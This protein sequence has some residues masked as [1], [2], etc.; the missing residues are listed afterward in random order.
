MH[1][2]KSLLVFLVIFLQSVHAQDHVLTNELI[3][4]QTFVQ[5]SL[6]SIH[7]LKSQSAY[8]VIK[9]DEVNQQSKIVLYDY[10]TKTELAVLVDSSRSAKI[11]FFT[12]YSFS[13]D[14]QKILLESNVEPIYRRS[15]RAEYWVY[16]RQTKQV[17]YLFGGKVQQA[18]FSPDGSKVAFVYQRNLFFKDLAQNSIEQ[19]TFDG[20]QHII[21]GLTDWV[22]E[23]EFGFVRA[24][25]WNADGT[26]IAFMRFDETEVP[27]FSMDIYGSGLYQYPYRFK[28]PKAGENNATVSLHLYDLAKK[29]TSEIQLLDNKPYYIPRFEF[30]PQTNRLVVQT[31]NRLQN[32]LILWDLDIESKMAKVL[33]EEKSDTYVDVHDNL[34]F[35]DR[36]DFIWTS[37]KSGYNHLYHY[38]ADGIL[39]RQLTKGPWD[40]TTFYG[41][42]SKTKEIYYASVEKSSIERV[43][44]AIGLNGK[45]KRA[46]T[47]EKGTNGVSFSA[48]FEYYIH[49]YE[50]V[51]T[52]KVYSLKTT[53][54]A[55]LVREIENNAEL[56]AK[57]KTYGFLTKEFSTIDINGETLNMWMIKP[58][59]F[60]PNKKYP[61]FMYQYSGPGS[62]KV[63]NKWHDDRDLWH[64]LL[65]QKG[66]IVVCVDGR[67][68]GFKGV[69]FKKVTY[70]Q[71]TKYETQD[72]IAVAKK[73][74]Q[75]AYID[76]N[77]IGIWGWSYGGHMATNCILKGN[78][79]FSLA[80]AVAPVTNWRFYDTIYTERFMRTPQENPSGYDLN[81]PLNY[82]HLLKG[83]YLLIHGSGDDN[84]HV[85][86]SMR[87]VEALVQA[88]KPFDLMIYPDKNHGIYG[89]NTHLHL[90]NKMTKFIENNL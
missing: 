18:R 15:T 26:V 10:A 43:V 25:D 86:N 8:T 80:I 52:P 49:T 35:L 47:P 4:N 89:G 40:V 23:E 87:M 42:N 12:A 74:S 39:K 19:L 44:Y 6:E 5:Q 72:Q 58:K 75:L 24:F 62:Q 55:T 78:D 54:N 36:G 27:E 51:N 67:G 53:K 79:I 11:P 81:S 16:D 77:R 63:A 34:R 41:V 73:L 68:T 83:K 60:N 57:A 70:R 3:W 22:Y 84:V 66:Y 59:D 56:K 82:A 64:Q 48:D 65:A 28:Y 30:T 29:Q 9:I 76:E 71:L 32:H 85:Q 61:L 88:N 31:L 14:E 7:P 90:Y 17:N 38:T 21:N 20:S 46:L 13:A 2:I 69:D 33:L 37:E 50:D 1:Q 45:R